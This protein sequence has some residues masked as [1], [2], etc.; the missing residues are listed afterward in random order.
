MASSLDIPGLK[1]AC[2]QYGDH[3]LQR[4]GVWRFEDD[5]P[6][7]ATSTQAYWIIFVH[8]GG[9]RDPRNTIHD[10]VPSIKHMLSLADLPKSAVRGFASLDY[11]LSPHPLFPQDPAST[12][13]NELREA[14]HPAHV[15]DVLSALRLLDTEYGIGS[16]YV[17]V[18]HSAGGTLVQQIIMNNDASYAWGPAAPLPAAIISISGIYDIRG[19]AE[20]HGGVYEVFATGAFGADKQIWDAASPA[21][22]TGNFKTILS[23][24]PRLLILATSAEDTLIDIPEIDAMEAKLIKDG[25]TPVVI[26]N[27]RLEHDEIWEDGT[28]VATLIADAVA[29]L[30]QQP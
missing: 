5:A 20:R 27:L 12:P 13:A 16:N 26:R 3:D 1:Y 28:Q 6:E 24:G 15:Q 25:V 29:K 8:G 19:L 23:N 9:W 2:H 7:A 18:G 14:E 21:K 4:V 10:F 22:Y 11:R 17:L 30:Q